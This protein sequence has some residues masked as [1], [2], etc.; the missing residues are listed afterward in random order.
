M[1]AKFQL[2]DTG[3]QLWRDYISTSHKNVEKA[4]NKRFYDWD[5]KAKYNRTEV[6]YE[7]KYDV[8]GYKYASKY[9]R[10]VNMYIEFE[11]T[12][13]KEASGIL[14]SKADFYVYIFVDDQGNNIAYVYKRTDLL[15]HL[16]QS[17]YKTVS[18][19]L[20]GDSN[21]KGWLAPL[22]DCKPLRRAV[23]DLDKM[24]PKFTSKIIKMT[25]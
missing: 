2:G 20:G 14:A 12:T 17:K 4:P 21:A 24:K 10:P 18:N 25:L 15:E 11:N 13:K 6:T 23:I 7:I 5:V 16:Q 3:E 8:S 1:N 19:S 9:N 22:E